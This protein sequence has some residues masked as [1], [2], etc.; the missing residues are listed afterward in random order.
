MSEVWRSKSVGNRVVSTKLS[1]E[2]FTSLQYY[3]KTSGE[4]INACLRRMIL[5]EV[6]RPSPK[7]I[8]AKSSFEYNK[9]KENFA[10]KV[11]GDDGRTVEIDEDFPVNSA[12]QLHDA[13][14]KAIEERNAFVRA[15]R[16]GSS[17]IPTK[18]LGRA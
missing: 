2:E 3:C 15:K 17:A 10:W 5:S 9:A 4:T 16:K 11:V 8:A 7:R 6:E 18:L 14:S 1:R 12:E 13:L